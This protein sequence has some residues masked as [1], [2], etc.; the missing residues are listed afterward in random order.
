[1]KLETSKLLSVLSQYQFFNWEN[2]EGNH[3]KLVIGLPEDI[4]EIKDFYDSFGFESVDNEYSDIKISKQQWIDIENKFFQWISPYLSTFNQTIV[5][6][7]LSNDWEGEIDLEDIEED[8]LAPLY[9]EYKEFLASNDLYDD[10]ATLV[11]ISRGYKIDDLGDFSTLGKM[12]ARNNKYLFFADGDKVFMFTDSLTLKVY[13][14]D[15][16]VLEKEKK[17]IERL[18]NPK[19]L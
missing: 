7:Y 8:E 5:T 17:K 3:H 12:A 4:V 13:F 9:K 6:P 15:Q 16:E 19:F 18:L 10:M 1:M 14:K 2:E 11:E